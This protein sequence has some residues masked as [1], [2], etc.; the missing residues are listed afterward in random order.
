MKSTTADVAQD[1]FHDF[2]SPIPDGSIIHDNGCGLS[3]AIRGYKQTFATPIGYAYPI[4]RMVVEATDIDPAML[5]KA[6]E[7]HDR[8]RWPVMRFSNMPAEQLSFPDDYFTHSISNFL[9]FMTKNDGVDCA[10][11][12]Y[13]TLQ[14]GGKAAITAWA[15]MPHGKAIDDV[16]RALRGEGAERM[17]VM[18]AKWW[19]ASHLK[20]VMQQGGFA[21]EDVTMETRPVYLR[22]EEEELRS[23]AETLW[24]LRGAPKGG[25][26]M[27]D[28]ENWDKAIDML[29]ERLKVRS[30]ENL[31]ANPPPTRDRS[32]Y[33]SRMWTT[34]GGAAFELVAHVAV[35]RKSKPAVACM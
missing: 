3:E 11:E 12:I 17:Y 34:Q 16:H 28:Q 18:P 30:T 10:K 9:I 13:R 24:G 4:E 23:Q 14:P 31:I 20:S 26:T 35:C 25:W 6:R 15:T 8:N 33:E 2:L 1:V 19:K 27:A 29:V 7:Y 21:E 22:M 5:K 32:S